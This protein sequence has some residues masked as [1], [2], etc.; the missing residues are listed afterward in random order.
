MHQQEGP[1][2]VQPEQ[3]GSEIL[4]TFRLAGVGGAIKGVLNEK[5]LLL[6]RRDGKGLRVDIDTIRRVRHHHTPVIP[7]GLTWIGVIT[8]TH[9]RNPCSIWSNTDLR[10]GNGCYHNFHLVDGA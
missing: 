3:R 8:L 1:F 2:G 7:Q 9:S 6:E 5:S 4:A 10:P